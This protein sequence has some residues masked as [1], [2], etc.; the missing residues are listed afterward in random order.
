MTVTALSVTAAQATLLDGYSTSQPGNYTL[1]EPSGSG[2]TFNVADGELQP[3]C[4]APGSTGFYWTGGSERLT[5][6]S[7]VSV[8]IAPA[9]SGTTYVGG[10]SGLWLGKTTNSIT[11]QFYVTKTGTSTWGVGEF[12]GDSQVGTVAPAARSLQSRPCRN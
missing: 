3:G 6:G 9:Q 11:G 2:T 1:F 8:Q 10:A 5:P 12:D 7:S 4:A